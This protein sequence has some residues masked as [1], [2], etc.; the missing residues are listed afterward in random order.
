MRHK[1]SRDEKGVSRSGPSPPGRELVEAPDEV[2]A[3]FAALVDDSTKKV[4][5]R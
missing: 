4:T 5:R 2:L 1:T 3:L